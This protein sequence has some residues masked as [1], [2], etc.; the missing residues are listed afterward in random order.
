MLQTN[1]TTFTS[2]KY[3][4]KYPANTECTW[5]IKVHEGYSITL[6][7]IERF[8]VEQSAGC[9]EDFVEVGHH[10]IWQSIL[11]EHICTLSCYV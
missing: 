9:S 5:D 10:Y 4:G 3:P 2:P 11:E 6:N 1:G 8:D 7:F